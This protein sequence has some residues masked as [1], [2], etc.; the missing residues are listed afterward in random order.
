[1]S[2]VSEILS[3][4]SISF[5]LRSAVKES[6]KRDPVDAFNDAQVLVNVL[7]SQLFALG[8]AEVNNGFLCIRRGFDTPAKAGTQ[9]PA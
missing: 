5:W 3:D 1:M 2:N 4:P 9:P 8:I 7:Q 6:L